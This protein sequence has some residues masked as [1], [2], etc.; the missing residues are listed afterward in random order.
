MDLDL[1]KNIL[2]VAVASS[3]VS[4][5]LIQKIKEG[6]SFKN[7]KKIIIVS[8]LVSMLLGTLFSLTFSELTLVNSLW[9]GLIS[10]IGADTLYK[11]FEDKIFTKFSDIDNSKTLTIDRSDDNV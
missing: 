7:S 8:F 4:T 1:I 11:A 3:I 6:F 2:I 9:V 10:F 5:T